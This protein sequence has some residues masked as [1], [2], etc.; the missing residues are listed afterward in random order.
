MS[1]PAPSHD[2][3]LANQPNDEDPNEY[4]DHRGIFVIILAIFALLAVLTAVELSR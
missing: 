1:N 2:D 3:P 4:N